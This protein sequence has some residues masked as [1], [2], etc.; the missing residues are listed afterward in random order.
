[1]EYVES[2]HFFSRTYEFDGLVY[3][4]TYREGS[5]ASGIAVEFGEND[6]GKIETIVEGLCRIHG[7]LS[8]HGIDHKKYFLRIDGFFQCCDFV[9]HLFI[10][11]EASGCIDD[12]Q[13]VDIIPVNFYVD[14]DDVE[15]ILAEDDF[16]E[17]E[18]FPESG[19]VD[20][21]VINKSE[22]EAVSEETVKSEDGFK[23]ADNAD[24]TED[25]TETINLEEVK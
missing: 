11:G 12:D 16:D 3:D 14:D 8:C 21:K 5:S 23:P 22:K 13:I 1:M 20:V 7:I 25:N 18:A 9:H 4:G 19:D 24:T 6:T 2:F 15:D 10:D 17:E